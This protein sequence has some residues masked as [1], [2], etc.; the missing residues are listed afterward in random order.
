[1]PEG[2]PRDHVGSADAYERAVLY[3]VD[4]IPDLATVRTWCRSPDESGILVVNHRDG[5]VVSSFK[6]Q[7]VSEVTHRAHACDPT[8]RLSFFVRCA[9]GCCVPEKFVSEHTA[10]FVGYRFL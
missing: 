9:T 1:M 10:C 6:N 5:A 7:P 4:T 8:L 3:A 2:C